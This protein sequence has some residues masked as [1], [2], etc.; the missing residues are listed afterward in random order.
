MTQSVSASAFLDRVTRSDTLP[1]DEAEPQ[2][3]DDL[4]ADADPHLY[5]RVPWE[6]DMLALVLKNQLKVALALPVLTIIVALGMLTWLTGQQVAAWAFAALGFQAIQLYL[7]SQFF[8]RPRRRSEQA[9]WIGMISATELLLAMSWVAPLYLF[10]DHAAIVQHLFLVACVLAV[11]VVRLLVMGSF[12]PVMLAGT[13]TMTLGIVIRCLIVAEPLYLSLAS[14]VLALELFFIFVARQLQQTMRDVV[15]FKA[16]KDILIAELRRQRDTATAERDKAE[17]ANRAKSSFL[18][19]MSHELRT[20]LNA[21]MGF[22]EILEREMF[23]PLQNRTYHAYAGDIHHSGSHLLALINDI[24]DLSRIE[25]GRR[26]LDNEPVNLGEVVGEANALLSLKARER[27]HTVRMEVD[28]NLP[29]LSGDH[30]ALYQVA[31]NLINNA[32]K[33]TQP[34]G[35]IHIRAGQKSDGTVFLS[36]K[37]NGPGIPAHEVEKALGAF[38]RGSMA[39]RKA[40]DGAGLG[41]SIVRGLMKLHD[42]DVTV[43]SQQGVGTE[44]LCSFPRSR[45]LDGPRGQVAGEA[46]VVSESQRKLIML[47]GRS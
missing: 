46:S 37:D 33:F 3:V 41:L 30:R 25:A 24:L 2:L 14:V 43:N 19:N 47:A 28:P 21:I 7:A 18:A 4:L 13:S 5:D 9:D 27:H 17:D 38:G 10:W 8:K 44:V 29:R 35:V 34:H 45:V 20:P 12:L 1:A 40:I 31:I 36:V 11:A 6:R 16:Q 26:E 42:G 32:I 15:V 23:G 22:S 39:T